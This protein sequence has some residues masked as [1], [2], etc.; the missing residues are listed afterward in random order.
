M[1]I[2]YEI[3]SVLESMQDFSEHLFFLLRENTQYTLNKCKLLWNL[4]GF[5]FQA[6]DSV[7]IQI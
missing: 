5:K 6:H 3:I 7:E 1:Y 4:L 2:L